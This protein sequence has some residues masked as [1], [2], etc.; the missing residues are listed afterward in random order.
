MNILTKQKNILLVKVYK[1]VYNNVSKDRLPAA[2]VL[3]RQL[4]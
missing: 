1:C 4:G 2:E 3:T